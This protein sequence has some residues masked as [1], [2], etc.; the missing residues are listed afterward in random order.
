V[1]IIS[2]EAVIYA[3]CQALRW[4]FAERFAGAEQA[5]AELSERIQHSND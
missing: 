4:R 1:G 5:I 3:L 2:V